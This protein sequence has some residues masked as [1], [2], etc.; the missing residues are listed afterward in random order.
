[1]DLCARGHLLRDFERR[2]HDAATEIENSFFFESWYNDYTTWQKVIF[3]LLRIRI[4]R[5]TEPHYLKTQT[6]LDRLSEGILPKENTP[7]ENS[8]IPIFVSLTEDHFF[9]VSLPCLP[10]MRMGTDGKIC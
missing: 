1:M 8:K 6:I 5:N 7:T 4:T 9:A 3:R 2:V 10:S